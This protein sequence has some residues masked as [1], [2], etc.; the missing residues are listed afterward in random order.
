[1]KRPRSASG[2]IVRDRSQGLN[3]K[4][5]PRIKANCTHFDTLVA[6]YHPTVYMFACQLTN[7]P[8]EA[9]VL[10]REVIDKLRKQVRTCRDED[11]LASILMSILIR[12]GLG[13]A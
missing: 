8:R 12:A 7:D 4:R 2:C 5:E 10:T 11:V 13:A 1:M 6:R 9:V 3:Q